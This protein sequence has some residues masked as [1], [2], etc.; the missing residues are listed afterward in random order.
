LFYGQK[1]T[2]VT[3]I[4]KQLLIGRGCLPSELPTFKRLATL[5]RKPD[6]TVENLPVSIAPPFRAVICKI[7]FTPMALAKQKVW[8]KPY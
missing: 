3:P 8:L 4:K 2:E 1:E 7:L 5:D 6:N